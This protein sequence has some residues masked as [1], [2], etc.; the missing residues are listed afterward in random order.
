MRLT[1][2]SP[3]YR[4]GLNCISRLMISTSAH[5]HHH[6]IALI[7]MEIS[8]AGVRRCYMEEDELDESIVGMSSKGLKR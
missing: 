4:L 3:P 6:Q 8:L 2:P 1:T 7:K 5:V